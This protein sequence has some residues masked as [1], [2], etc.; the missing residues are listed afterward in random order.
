MEETERIFERLVKDMEGLVGC[1]LPH[2]PSDYKNG[3]DQ[4]LG[5]ILHCCGAMNINAEAGNDEVSE[6][7]KTQGSMEYLKMKMLRN[8]LDQ[9]GK[10][11][12]GMLKKFQK[13]LQEPD[14]NNYFGTRMEVQTAAILIQ[15]RIN[16]RQIPS[17]PKKGESPDFAITWEMTKLYVECTN[18][19]YSEATPATKP[20]P[21]YRKISNSIDTK[22]QKSYAGMKTALFLDFT[23]VH[24]HSADENHILRSPT[25]FTDF[26]KSVPGC[27]H[28]GSVVLLT[29]SFD[30]VK[31]IY[32]AGF[33]RED[34]H[35]IS[36]ELKSFLGQHFS[37]EG[38]TLS[39]CL[40][41][42]DT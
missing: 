1:T 30:P 9:I 18:S 35:G 15:K 20:L 17:S 14:Y 41:P 42:L 10:H 38:V 29:Y 36:S 34:N 37:G 11:D 21:P 28:F 25:S 31:Q 12:P 8:N 7:M 39:D 6:D 32:S 27:T 16:F 19:H 24:S 2:D 4:R 33:A 23:G 13:R 5:R 3:V 26:V 22:A 40:V